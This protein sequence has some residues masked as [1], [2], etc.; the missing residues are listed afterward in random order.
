MDII[1]K[2]WALLIIN[3][4]GNYQR[5]RYSEIR[6][7]LGEINSKVLSD[8]LKE[9]E[10]AGLIKR[11]AYAEIP[12]RVEYSLT[13]DGE[14]LRKAIMPLMKWVYSK[15]SGRTNTPCDTAYLETR[16]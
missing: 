16:S 13:E 2:K 9:L 12:P 4:V 3:A 1:S 15:N 7:T 11:E 6:D 10:E 14:A 8:R 5:I